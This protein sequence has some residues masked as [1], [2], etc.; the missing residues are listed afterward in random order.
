MWDLS[1][2]EKTE[3]GKA[4]TKMNLGGASRKVFSLFHCR[5]PSVTHPMVRCALAHTPCTSVHM[6]VC[7]CELTVSFLP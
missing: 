3:A 2:G 1:T 6:H 5:G 7:A 4:D